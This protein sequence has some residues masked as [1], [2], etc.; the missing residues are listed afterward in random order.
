V[1]I[2][3]GALLLR[4]WK[5]ADARPTMDIDMLG[6]IGNDP[7]IL[8]ATF[9]EICRIVVEDD[10]LTFDPACITSQQITKESDYVGTRILFHGKLENARIY[11]QVD[12]GF[13]D[14]TYPPPIEMEMPAILGQATG[15]PTVR[16]IIKLTTIPY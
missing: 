2:L 16:F 12:S 13:G 14:S 15:G 7:Q 11:M 4:V 3:K 10:G 5:V 1:F 9:Q 8:E 6:R